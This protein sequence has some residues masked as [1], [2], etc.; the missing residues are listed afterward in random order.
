MA[1]DKNN[2][3]IVSINGNV[4]NGLIYYSAPSPTGGLPDRSVM[5]C[6]GRKKAPFGTNVNGELVWIDNN[7][8]E[9]P[10]AKMTESQ[11]EQARLET[12][13]NA[14]VNVNSPID[15]INAIGQIGAAQS[16]E[17]GYNPYQLTGYAP[18][19]ARGA[20]LSR[21]A[22]VANTIRNVQN[23][24]RIKNTQTRVNTTNNGERVYSARNLRR[25]QARADAERIARENK[26]SQDHLRTNARPGVT[27]TEY[28]YAGANNAYQPRYGEMAGRQISP[29]DYE[30]LMAYSSRL[31]NTPVIRN[32]N[33]INNLRYNS[34]HL[35]TL[36]GAGAVG[37][38]AIALGNSQANNY[39]TINTQ[40]PVINQ[41][42]VYLSNGNDLENN[43]PQYYAERNLPLFEDGAAINSGLVRAGWSHGNAQ[44][45]I[46]IN[47]PTM[48]IN[49]DDYFK[50]TPRRGGRNGTSSASTSTG[51]PHVRQSLP[52]VARPRTSLAVE[53]NLDPGKIP[54]SVAQAAHAQAS[55]RQYG[56]YAGVTPRDWMSLAGNVAGS[57]GNWLAT[58]NSPRITIAEPN[59]PFIEM[60]VRL[61][62]N[63]NN[64]PQIANVEE[65]AR[66]NYQNIRENTASSSAALARMQRVRNA[67][68]QNINELEA[69]RENI[70]TQLTNADRANRQQVRARN[71]RAMNQYY[72]DLA[73]ARTRQ[74]IADA[75][76]KSANQAALSNLFNNVNLSFQDFLGRMDRRES[77]NNTLA[78][79]RG[80]NP[81]YDDR[82]F[83]DNGANFINMYLQGLNELIRK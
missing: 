26:S 58:R 78:Y 19:V 21:S 61:K 12:P 51:L 4:K 81:D 6:G 9:T 10:I 69:Q 75:Q 33:F 44:S 52:A 27:Q 20:G 71:A 30:Y 77:F 74:S 57:I 18:N 66:R 55:G 53:A 31:A 2:A 24:T 64:R 67:A 49:L 48:N 45:H 70:E 62:T 60:P 23:A 7:G 41:N 54:A 56:E 47:I 73:S 5:R 40:Q 14:G 36:A 46:G 82:M 50:E 32:N 22:R 37:A 15:L 25:Q 63:Y 8:N 13:N 72:E 65:Q 17:F 80:A 79:L 76:R 11:F 1:K 16:G 39:G 43:H 38:G 42:G 68:T 28:P 34:R 59:R 29:E 83:K 35:Q 3:G